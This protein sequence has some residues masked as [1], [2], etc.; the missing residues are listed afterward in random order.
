MKKSLALILP[1]FIFFPALFYLHQKIQIHVE[2]YRLSNNYRHYSELVDRR[3]NLMYN[4]S[5]EVSLAKVNQWASARNFSPVGTRRMIAL[6]TKKDDQVVQNNKPSLLSRF[7][8]ASIP[9]SVAL[10][11]DKE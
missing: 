6:N 8:R 4:F 10:A 1:I 2:A 11:D 5:K 3:D 7:L 9:T